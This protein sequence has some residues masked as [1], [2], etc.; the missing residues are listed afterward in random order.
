MKLRDYQQKIIDETRAA[1]R[2]V[3]RVL[4]QLPTGGGKT[5]VASFIVQSAEKKG[6]TVAFIC[7][8]DF[9]V[10]QTSNTFEKFGIDFSHVAAGRWMNLY[11]PVHV[12]MVA[13]LRNRMK[14]IDPPDIAIWDEAQH[15]GAKT[16]HAIMDEWKDTIHL[17]LSATPCRLDGKGLDAFFDEM[18]I[19][20]SPNHLM[21]IGALNKY[22]AFCPSSPDMTG[23][24]VRAGDYRREEVEDL[25]DKSV[26]IGDMVQ[27]YKKI[28]PGTLAVYF[29][30]SIAHSQNIADTFNANGIPAKHLD[31]SH[32]T[33]ER[34]QAAIQFA[35]RELLVLT[36]VDLFGEG[37]DLAAQ[38]GRVVRIETVGL[39][40]PTQSLSLHMQQIGRALRPGDEPATILDHAGNILR[41]GLPDDDREWTLR[42]VVKTGNKSTVKQ[43]LECFAMYPISDNECP[44]CGSVPEASE[45]G[46][47]R[48]VEY[49]DGDLEEVDQKNR[50]M[51]KKVEEWECHSIGDLVALGKKRGYKHPE[52]WAAHLWTA[53][54]ARRRS[55]I[56]GQQE[57]QMRMGE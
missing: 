38:A 56:V 46:G 52:K 13:T 39:A 21:E 19:G 6:K 42:G 50:K 37:Y 55:H 27:H 35:N 11:S 8:R 23:T 4:I 45:G 32:S 49:Q 54:E 22:R 57:F 47:G 40:R 51:S 16:W 29:A 28:A 12:C 10:D 44:H 26:V 43:C 20:P 53:K 3:R 41:H 5:V 14:R 34:K 18:V 30:S 2:R 25:M 1:L 17:G 36:N 48:E 24:K 7:H 33:F 15:I 9:L 31:G